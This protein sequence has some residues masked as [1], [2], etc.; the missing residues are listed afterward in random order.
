MIFD[1]DPAKDAANRAKHR[2]SLAFGARVFDDPGAI[3]L[4]SHREIDGELR[5]KVVGVVDGRLHTAVFVQRG[6]VTRL[7]SVR[8]SNGGEQRDRDRHSGGPR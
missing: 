8:R 5:Y 3:V 6:E 7:I 2:L 1:F 4:P